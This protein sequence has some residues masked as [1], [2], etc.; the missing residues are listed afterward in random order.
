MRIKLTQ[1][2][3]TVVAYALAVLAATTTA[4]AAP[5]AGA[6]RDGGWL[7]EEM[8]LPLTVK[9]P[10]DLA[11]KAA[12][13]RQY[14]IFNL[15]ARGKIAWDAGDF[16]TA[17][18]KWETLLR[19]PGLDPQLD[20][21]VRPLALEARSRAGGSAASLPPAAGA[22]PASAPVA[23][24]LPEGPRR[25]SFTVSG[26]VSGGGSLGPGG[27]VISLKRAD[28][29]TPRPSPARGK[30]M[31]QLNK[32][33]VPKILPVTVGS[34]V[35]FKNEDEI[36]HN[37]FSLSRPN[38]F[39]TGLYKSG[40]SYT[41]TF[42]RPGAVQLL[43]NIHASMIGYVVVLDTPWYGQADAAGNFAIKGVPP[44][45]Y[46]LEA[47]HEG[48]SKPSHMKLSV[49]NESLRSVAVRVAGDRKAPTSVPDK[50][51]KARQVQLGY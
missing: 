14:L 23:P 49:G 35:T 9:T 1:S 16:A 37:V 18:Q 51:G 21:A 31:N 7:G 33:F 29:A 42:N 13:E 3:F 25:T 2:M 27:T 43:C 46:D 12:A 24:V 36:F 28:G 44:G 6:R 47:W 15:L 17:A 26:T 41:K 8:P 11:L 45:E 30:S 4:L 32:T 39:D 19:V 48:S 38:D 34:T 5:E 40:G 10:Q 20:S 50:Y 22:A